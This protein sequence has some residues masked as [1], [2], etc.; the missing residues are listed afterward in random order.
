M[1]RV[2]ILLILVVAFNAMAQDAGTLEV[3]QAP[4][5]FVFFNG[6][7]KSKVVACIA[8]EPRLFWCYDFNEFL[9]ALTGPSTAKEI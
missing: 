5:S 1:K 2:L 7:E 3:P 8:R 9:K 6:A 4:G